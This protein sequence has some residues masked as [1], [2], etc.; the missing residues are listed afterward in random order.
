MVS[1]GAAIQNETA[2]F[3]WRKHAAQIGMEMNV[4]KSALSEFISAKMCNM[5]IRIC[6]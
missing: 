3:L 2:S 5:D 1:A 4:L 6:F